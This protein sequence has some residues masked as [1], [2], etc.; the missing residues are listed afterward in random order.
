MKKFNTL[1]LALLVAGTVSAQNWTLDKSHAKVGFG[2]THLMISDVEG[3]FNSFDAKLTSSK[4]D[5]S[6]AV[7]EFTADV[8]SINTNS[9]GRDKHLKNEDF[10][11]AP[12]FGTLSFKG[13]SL[14]KVE[15]KKYK[16]VGDLT[17]HGVT[18]AV[19]FDVIVN[20]PVAHP[21]NKKT[22]AGFKV[23]GTINRGDFNLGTKYP[24]AIL[25]EEVAITAN[26]EFAKD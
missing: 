20:G 3:A 4:D 12:K 25:S 18:K 17:M 24:S 21:F 14:T 11:D 5:F 23:T 22:V 6:D 7:V 13:K 16:L 10:F 9:E 8:N 26:A 2:I 19:T 15:G 1:L